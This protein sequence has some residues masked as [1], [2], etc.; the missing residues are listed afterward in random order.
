MPGSGDAMPRALILEDVCDEI[1]SL[2]RE[3]AE[4]GFVVETVEGSTDA[5]TALQRQPPDLILVGL[6]FPAD[7]ALNFIRQVKRD[8]RFAGRPVAVYTNQPDPMQVLRGLEAG[9]DGFLGLMRPPS[10]ML[11]AIR[12]IMARGT[13]RPPND[14]DRS[15]ISFRTQPF[16]LAMDRDHLLGIL[17]SSFE[18]MFHVSQQYKQEIENRQ[19]AEDEA[20]RLRARFDLAVQGSGDGIWDWDVESNVVYF[21]PRGKE[22]IGYRDHEI[23]NEFSEWERRIHPEDRERALATIRNYF[24]NRTAIYELEHRLQHKDGSYRWILARGTAMRDGHGRPFRMSGSHTDI[25]DRK[26][27]EEQARESET[28]FRDLFENSTDLIQRV[29]PDGSYLFVNP[30]WVRATGYTEEEA[31][32]LR[33]FEI[34]H[35]DDRERAQA[36]FLRIIAGETAVHIETRVITKDGRVIEVEGTSSCQFRDG[37]PLATRG[38][39]RDVTERNRAQRLVLAGRQQLRSVLDNSPAVIYI[40]GLDGRYLTVNNRFETL[41]GISRD[42][43]ATKTD[44]DIFPREMAEIFRANDQR[45]LDTGEPI[46]LEEIAPHDDG[47]HTYLTVKFPLRDPSGE[48][49]A[50]CGISTDITARK[51][52]EEERHRREAQLRHHNA[53]IMGLAEDECALGDD[54]PQALRSFTETAART[55]NAARASVWLLSLDHTALRCFNLY[56]VD[57]NRHSDGVEIQAKDFP[58]YFQALDDAQIVA[59]C[60]AR[61]DPR[62][63]E[64]ADR[65]LVSSGTESVLAAP[66]RLR[67]G[68]VGVF[69]IE[70]AASPRT[71]S[72]EEQNF[73]LSV[74]S[75]ISL[76]LEASERKQAEEEAHAARDAAEAANRAKSAFLAT[77]SHE[78]RTPMNAIIG[79]T[80][81]V[82]DS[83]LGAEQREYLD[84]VKKSADHLLSL[85]NEILDFSKIEAGKLD[86]EEV[87]F[88]I[89]ET[90]GDALVT[91]APR[92]YQRGLELAGRVSPEVP[93][94]LRGDPGRIRQI[95]VNLIGNA[96]KF[97]DSGEIVVEVSV[98]SCPVPVAAAAYGLTNGKWCSE[99]GP[100][101][102]QI[103]L[104]FAV[105]DTGI[106]IPKEK[107]E[108]I[109]SPF[110]QADS[111]TTRKYGGTG[112]GLTIS[113]RLVELMGGQIWVESEIGQGSAFQ[114]TATF[115]VAHG[116]TVPWQP[117][118]WV[119]VRGLPVLVID[120][121]A[122]NRRILEETLK[123]WEMRPTCVDSGAAALAVMLAAKR[124]GEPF[125]LVLLDCQMPE[126][127]G[128]ELAERILQEP[129]FVAPTVMMLTS[130]GRPG[131]PARCRA[132]GIAS[133][134]T[135]PVRQSELRKAIQT[136][137][138][139]KSERGT[140]DRPTANPV[141]ATRP[142]HIL[143][144]E[145][146]PINQKLATRLLEKQGHTID[147]V[148]SG[149][150]VVEVWARKPF[151]LI[152]M[153]VQMPE[154]DGFEA[155]NA[156][157]VRE[158]D[159]GRRI[160]ILAM[161][162]HAMKG[163]RERCLNAGMDGY[164]SK[165]IHSDE[166]YSAIAALVDAA[167]KPVE[168][169]PIVPKSA[170]PLRELVAW[171]EALGYV[172]GDEELLRELIQTFVVECPVWMRS[173]D[174]ALKRNDADAIHAVC[175][176]FKNSLYLFGAK[177]AGDHASRLELM[178]RDRNLTGAADVRKSLQSELDTLMPALREFAHP[179][180]LGI[181]HGDQP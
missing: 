2:I 103:E 147:V 86:L 178:G 75:L 139:A 89:R 4:A 170:P 30:A 158:R 137:L 77:M 12:Q 53:V 102:S 38:V 32:R 171:D 129:E 165:P 94:A 175:H 50:V 124:M 40:K 26:A 39:F 173:L 143:L 67:G 119:E 79:M 31:R 152:L 101:S 58:A 78:I 162:A 140:S 123:Q 27:S 92:A 56:D 180:K 59:A 1:R 144:A 68:V 168:S 116:A 10:E 11:A 17:M 141:A 90:L 176:P 35:P 29:R 97:T 181:A 5:Q 172:G 25:S 100:K 41:F 117:T 81:L 60:D 115:R 99:I 61:T 42:N 159:S 18:D 9:A 45:V 148:S 114:F 110:T 150:E 7:D 69:C 151:D 121:N 122:T 85:I 91:L 62:T 51:R 82:L 34:V 37:K 14:E 16:V 84:L 135:K 112:L 63:G 13:R 96:I 47:P 113:S 95:V 66:L 120:D 154:M 109:F 130:G 149:R 74:A 108:L 44:Y 128:F 80:D 118:P 132:L 134:L 125:G 76:A 70:H 136:A 57:A 160:P 126:M 24:E 8:A 179:T 48:I 98:N 104:H 33:V 131:D 106:G 111:T 161:T 21:S 127:D 19:E 142:L 153:D 164:V 146:N 65:H 49:N 15:L 23:A 174:A 157:R 71:W 83:P 72:Q 169:S 20:H 93:D 55:L 177:A 87:D 54:L 107:Q 105:R 156:I 52:A 167:P 64:Y 46:E 22:M 145:D 36:L 133:F 73:A 163:D 28:R 166:L 155:T 3:L 43:I 88:S 6:H 138:G